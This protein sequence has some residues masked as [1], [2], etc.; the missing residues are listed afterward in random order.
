MQYQRWRPAVVLSVAAIGVI[1]C[2][3]SR[4]EGLSRKP[5]ASAIANSGGVG[6]TAD[7]TC[8]AA[9]EWWKAN[10]TLSDSATISMV[11]TVGPPP[12]EDRARPLCMVRVF[13]PHGMNSA[14][15]AWSVIDDS[16][17]PPLLRSGSDWLVLLRFMAD[18]PD[19]SLIGY[20][21][22]KVRCALQRSW[23]GGDDGDS[24]YIR[25]PWYREELTCWE[26]EL[27]P[28]DTS[29]P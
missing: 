13:V 24:T 3:D 6:A 1:A 25:E 10:L 29:N 27:L 20:Q 4:T 12:T 9:L 2:K 19:G 7:T 26:A 18:G 11:D 21:R 16:V 15:A 22:G 17:P 28:S 23:D 5:P 8:A 14:N